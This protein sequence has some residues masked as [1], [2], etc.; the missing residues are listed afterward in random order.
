MVRVAHLR[1]ADGTDH[2]Y[3]QP[4]QLRVGE[5]LTST[6]PPPSF[7]LEA[8]GPGTWADGLTATV[9]YPATTQLAADIASSQGGAIHGAD[10]FTLTLTLA[11]EQEIYRNVTVV[12]GPFRVDRQ[13]MASHLA[14]V[15]G[16]LPTAP[17]K[18]G[19]YSATSG[20]GGSA[21]QLEDYN[22]DG[23]AGKVGLY[24][25]ENA[26][27]VNI[28][29]IPP[30]TPG[31]DLP[32][33]S[34]WAD[35]AAYAKGRRAFLI[36]DPPA[37]P[38]ALDKAASWSSDNGM[39]GPAMS[40]AAFY[41]PR[42]QYPDPL[43]GGQIDTFA[44]SGAIAGIFARTDGSRGVWKAPAG[45]DAGLSGVVGLSENLT[46][47][48]NGTLNQVAVNALR[49]FRDVGSVIWG[50][51][52]L[53]GSDVLSDDYKYIPVRRLALFIE[54]SL[55]RGTQWVVFEPNDEPL[56]S[57]IRLSVGSFMQDLF[58]KGAFQ[59]TTPRDAYYVRC[60]SE[61]TTQYDIDR[62]IVNIVV[63]FA[64]LKPAEFVVISIEQ[65]T[66]AAV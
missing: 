60:D 54:E 27:L 40:Y 15:S 51:R 3:A 36:V 10:L 7:L 18:E 24:A 46:N 23:G 38:L 43:S 16:P 65:K 57:Q 17:P 59:G 37:A 33:P 26:D 45:L 35:A 6:D 13:L 12:D 39:T 61:T 66:A 29:V 2:P 47:D 56:W 55:Y 63:G 49:T 41:Y 32:A 28:I 58:R 4:A 20:V 8:L 14:Q 31:G 19:S 1:G 48:E 64:P 25:L 5:P 9:N 21:V 53:R 34:I 22:A 62:G 44:P 42:I 52:T 11:S 30:P 50:A